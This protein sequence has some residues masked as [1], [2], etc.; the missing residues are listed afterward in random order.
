MQTGSK[1][2]VLWGLTSLGTSGN[3]AT[4]RSCP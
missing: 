1:D 3:A 2:P 4:S